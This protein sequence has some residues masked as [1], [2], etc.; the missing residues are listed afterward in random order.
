MNDFLIEIGTEEL[1]PKALGKLINAFKQGVSDGLKKA[2]ISFDAIEQFAGPRR[3][4]LRI[5]VLSPAQP[6]QSIERRGPNTKA[7]FDAD[8]NPTKALEGFLTSVGATVDQIEK[9]ATDKGEYVF[10]KGEQKGLPTTKLLPKIIQDSLKK[11]PIPKMMRW[12]DK[13]E[14]F[15]RPVRWLLSMYG[16]DIVPMSLF[17]VEA[18]NQSFGH[19]F[20]HPDMV[21]ISCAS[22]YESALEKAHVNVC[23][24]SR[25]EI[26]KS[27]VEAIAAKNNATA[28]LPEALLDEIASINEWPTALLCAFDE[29]FLKVPSEC[30]ISA[31]QQ[32][33]K[34]V[35][36]KNDPSTP[37]TGSGT[38]ESGTEESGSLMPLFITVSNIESSKPESVIKGNEK[39]VCARLSDAAF[40]YETDL[41]TPLDQHESKLAKLTFQ[42]KLGS[43]LDKTKRIGALAE[44]IAAQ[45]GSDSNKAK[46]A[47]SLC[48][49]D[50]VTEMVME[51]PELQGLMGEYYAN[52]MGEDADVATAINEHYW[53][54]FAGDHVPTTATGTALS[55]ADNIDTLVGIF[56]I[57]QKPTGSK[58]PYALRRQAIGL[59]RIIT[60]NK[61]TVD[62]N[63]LV[64]QA[65]AQ[66]GSQLENAD[67]ATDVL[68]FISDRLKNHY[69]DSGIN[70][71]VF[72]AVKAA[73]PHS[74]T[75]FD[76]RIASV[77]EFEKL[78]EADALAAANKRVRNIL[79][80]LDAVP[81]SIDESL[82]QETAEKAL[83]SALNKATSEGQA[84]LEN[85]DYTAYFTRLS[86][87]KDPLDQFFIDVMVMCDDEQQK[88]NRL[89]LLNAVSQAFGCVADVSVLA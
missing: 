40:F 39:V 10:F 36:L 23:A 13:T 46:R 20:H 78:P 56:G 15:V 3:L 34:C 58:D 26:I 12:G 49:S 74:I 35:A 55:L 70:P 45:A 33:Q 31:L 83:F 17:G 43:V 85:A 79:S 28:I 9:I 19:R 61:L 89:A 47:A 25:K 14:E 7:C 69:A 8:G 4:A 48:K 37:S 57:N 29:A 6:D 82:F 38:E 73:N 51:F 87:L 30:L 71:A 27:Q 77:I 54:K 67:T 41:K 22:E 64:D 50:L 59:I 80:K 75:D 53:P 72:E 44:S 65:V 5:K 86:A 24:N 11:L 60:E 21:S 42:A 18:A 81:S 84:E 1:P 68:A 88:A 52:A 16:S 66:Y 2:N 62:L 63:V 76:A 32:H